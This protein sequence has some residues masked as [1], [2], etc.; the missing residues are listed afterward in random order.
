MKT[1]VKNATTLG[2]SPEQFHTLDTRAQLHRRYSSLEFKITDAAP[3]Q[4]TV[5]IAQDKSHAGNY[6]D[7]KRLVEI[8]HETFDDLVTPRRLLVRPVPYQPAPSEV[9]TP[10]WIKKKAQE[11]GKKVKEIA[12]ELGVDAS[13]VAAYKSGS[14]P[15]SGVV[16]AMLYYYFMLPTVA[17]QSFTLRSMVAYNAN[18]MDQY[19]LDTD[20][21]EYLTLQILETAGI[22]AIENG[23]AYILRYEG[24][25]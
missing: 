18:V 10:D 1:L 5:L 19:P 15:L 14:K 16:K 9:V 8:A 23:Q 22:L 20:G 13:T 11:S 7:T 3:D 4:V 6:F 2:L 24:R 12:H 25:N 21:I 17:T